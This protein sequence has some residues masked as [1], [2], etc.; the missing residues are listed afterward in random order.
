MTLAKLDSDIKLTLARHGNI[1]VKDAICVL[2]KVAGDVHAGAKV[3][4]GLSETADKSVGAALAV[5]TS[6]ETAPPR[7]A[8]HAPARSDLRVVP[9]SE[10][11]EIQ[12]M[13]L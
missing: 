9:P 3:L 1:S 6:P 7:A 4:A 11:D 5:P 12:E 8:T 2:N 10:D 13:M